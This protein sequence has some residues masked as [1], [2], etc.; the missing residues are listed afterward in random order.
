MG[1]P[2]LG[3]SQVKRVPL[4]GLSIQQRLPL[5]ICILLL[6]III[7]FS[8]ASYLGVKN[9]SLRMGKERL[10]SLTRQLSSMFGQSAPA[11]VAT[12]RSVA[13]KDPVKKYLLSGEK[14]ADTAVLNTLQRLRLDSSW[15]L[16][17]LLN[18]D[19][20][21]IL[22]SSLNNFEIKINRDS[23]LSDLSLQPDSCKLGKLYTVGDSIF[24]PIAAAVTDQNKIIGYLV[25]WKLQLA[26]T[27]AIAQFSQLLGE[28][29]KL[30]IGNADG[31]VWTDLI[32]PVSSIPVNTKDTGNFFRYTGLNKVPV[33][34]SVRP[35]S[36]TQWVVLIELSQKE[37]LKAANRVLRSIII[38]G[39]VLVIIGIVIAWIISRN[40]T[41]P[42]K[43]LTRAAS[44][45]AAVIILLPYRFTVRMN[46]ASCPVLSMKWWCRCI[47]QI[48][49]W[50]NRYFSEPTS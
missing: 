31:S 13:A 6:C 18:A 24:Y 5:L 3:K 28:S 30:Y 49:I 34:A 26:T 50:R 7:T 32:R 27:K 16:V 9:A 20:Q 23:V 33:I 40:I 44:A 22:N 43:Q 4:T 8:W 47:M 42:L 41:K 17:E 19:H 25:R 15:V 35:I 14:E 48:I 38:L 36:N 10:N 12:T 46:W 2:V 37:V 11:V 21:V 39:A 1:K 45:I 29:A